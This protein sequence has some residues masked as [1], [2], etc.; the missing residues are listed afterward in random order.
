MSSFLALDVGMEA[1]RALIFKKE[2]NRLVILSYSCEKNI[3]QAIEAV[4]AETDFKPKGVFLTLPADIL[5]GRIIFES[6]SRDDYNAS[7]VIDKN[8]KKNICQA[9]LRQVQQSAWQNF[10]QNSGILSEELEFIELKILETKLD[11]YQVS[12]LRGYKGKYLEFRVF[13]S[14]LPKFYLNDLKRHLEESGLKSFR[15]LHRAQNLGE[16]IQPDGIIF[17]GIETEFTQIFLTQNSQLAFLAEFEGG[18]NNFVRLLSHTFGLSIQGAKD[19]IERYIQRSLSEETRARL[20]E[21]FLDVAKEWLADLKSKLKEFKGFPPSIFFI[22][23][24]AAEIPEIQEVLSDQDWQIKLIYPEIFKNIID[25][26]HTL[27]KPR[28]ISL[29]LLCYAESV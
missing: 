29:I 15:I 9:V 16:I 5:R 14:F 18:S 1:V 2:K 22:F 10:F 19:F 28:D 7:K 20:R 25:T 11:G 3:H 23:G 8:E 21:M 13:A 12:D 17:I 6:F 24:E 27:D 4:K 26:T